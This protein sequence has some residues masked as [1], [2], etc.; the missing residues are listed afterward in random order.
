V[1]HSWIL[2]VE[3]QLKA[4][5]NIVYNTILRKK[6]GKRTLSSCSTKLRCEMMEDEPCKLASK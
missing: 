6:I 1:K 3:K 4:Y 2:I 5:K